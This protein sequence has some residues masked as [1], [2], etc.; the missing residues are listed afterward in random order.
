M[1][2]EAVINEHASL[3]TQLASLRGQINNLTTEVDEQKI[4]VN[5]MILS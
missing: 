5:N 2:K 3:E 1:E 4:K